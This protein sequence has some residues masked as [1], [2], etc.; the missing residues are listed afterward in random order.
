MTQRS[1]QDRRTGRA[2][3]SLVPNRSPAS[4]CFFVTLLVTPQGWCRDPAHHVD[5]NRQTEKWGN[6]MGPTEQLS[7]ILP[8]CSALVDRIQVMQM[9]DPTPCEKFTVHDVL[10]HMMGLGG[11]FAYMFRGEQPPEPRPSGVYGWVPSKEFRTVMDDLLESV[12]SPGALE[13][14]IESPFGPM[15]GETFA[16]LVAFD[17]LVHSWDLATATGQR[18]ALPSDVVDAVASFAHAGAHRRHARRRHVQAPDRCRSVR[19]SDRA[20]R[21]IQRPNGARR[22]NAAIRR[23]EPGRRSHSSGTGT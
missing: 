16:R 14:T 22:L 21:G 17:G 23:A 20:A 7:Y 15:D 3:R 19:R 11:T 8:A 12:T 13:R 9:N 1:R 4:S 6:D 10:D 2:E 5:E 18:L